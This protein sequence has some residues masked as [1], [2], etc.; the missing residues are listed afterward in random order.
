M[1]YLIFK[2]CLFK[3]Q[4]TNA[5]IFRVFFFIVVDLDAPDRTTLWGCDTSLNT[6]L[7]LSTRVNPFPRELRRSPSMSSVAWTPAS[8]DELEYLRKI[9]K[10]RK[11]KKKK[12]LQKANLRIITFHGIPQSLTIAKE[13]FSSANDSL[14]LFWDLLW[15]ELAPQMPYFSD[16]YVGSILIAGPPPPQNTHTHSFPG[17]RLLWVYV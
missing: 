11:S 7:N 10:E 4:T 3:E 8:T 5:N 9:E 14:F 12:I 17:V 13:L 2:I 1:Q 6:S 15:P 16:I